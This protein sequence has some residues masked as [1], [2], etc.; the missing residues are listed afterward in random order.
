[1]CVIVGRVKEKYMDSDMLDKKM[2]NIS[3]SL[4]QLKSCKNDAHDK[5]LT[6]KVEG[7]GGAG[8]LAELR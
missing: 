7:D 4:S 3:V 2:P 8:E 5:A 6:Y 1:M